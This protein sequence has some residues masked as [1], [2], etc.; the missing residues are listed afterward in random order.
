M[1]LGKRIIPV[2]LAACITSV[3]PLTSL[4]LPAVSADAEETGVAAEDEVI[5]TQDN[6]EECDIKIN[7][8]TTAGTYYGIDGKFPIYADIC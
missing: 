7:S 5:K 8:L 2:L 1:R 4:A 6:K 3:T